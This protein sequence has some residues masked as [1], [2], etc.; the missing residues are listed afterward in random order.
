[1]ETP[2]LSILICSVPSRCYEFLPNLLRVLNPQCNY[3]EVELLI[4]TDNRKM[5]IGEKR[6]KLKS[7]AKGKYIVYI[8]D[9][10]MISDNYVREILLATKNNTDCIL[11]NEWKTVND[12]EGK[13]IKYSINYINMKW[14]N[15]VTYKTPNSRMAIKK[16]L[17]ENIDFLHQN[18]N[19]DDE[20]GER[21]LPLLK[22]EFVIDKILYFY[23]FDLDNTTVN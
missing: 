12:R 17:V 10:D 22:T 13:I 8:D 19:E 20:W 18:N 5:S 9:D 3:K 2:L 6:N 14:D 15:L 23:K 21:I 16:E 4:L 7:I 11:F 1:M